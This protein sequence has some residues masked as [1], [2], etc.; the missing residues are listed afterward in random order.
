MRPR[1]TAPAFV[2]GLDSLAGLTSRALLV[3]IPGLGLP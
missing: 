3:P 2:D 1:M